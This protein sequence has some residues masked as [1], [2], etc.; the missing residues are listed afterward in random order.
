M[1]KMLQSMHAESI[2]L[3]KIERYQR[4]VICFPKAPTQSSLMLDPCIRGI[5]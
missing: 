5:I 4:H 1:F 3:R 2:E